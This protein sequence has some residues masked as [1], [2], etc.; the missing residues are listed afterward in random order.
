MLLTYVDA[1]VMAPAG[2]KSRVGR[3]ID[4]VCNQL[5][6]VAIN[7]CYCTCT[8]QLLRQLNLQD[9]V[10]VG[11][12][13]A[14]D[15]VPAG[16]SGVEQVVATG[17]VAEGGFA[18]L[19]QRLINEQDACSPDGG[20][21]AGAAGSD[22]GAFVVD[23]DVGIGGSSDIGNL[24][25]AI[26]RGDR[27]RIANIERHR[28][29]SLHATVL[30][31]RAG[32]NLPGGACKAGIF[33][34]AAAA[35][36]FVLANGRA[37]ITTPRYFA[38]AHIVVV[39]LQVGAANGDG[40]GGAGR[41][42]GGG[43][44]V[45]AQRERAT[46]AATDQHGDALGSQSAQA[47]VDGLHLAGREGTL[48][49]AIADAQ[50]LHFVINGDAVED[51]DKAL[52]K[53]SVGI[54]QVGLVVQNLRFRGET[55][56]QFEVHCRLPFA[57]TGGQWFG[58]DIDILNVGRGQANAGGIVGNVGGA[59]WLIEL[60][61]ANR[62]TLALEALL[63]ELIDLVGSSHLVA[64]Q[65][66]TGAVFGAVGARHARLSADA[67]WRLADRDGEVIQANDGLHQPVDAGGQLRVAAL[68]EKFAPQERM[69]RERNVQ[70]T[71]NIANRRLHVDGGMQRV[72]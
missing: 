29:Y 7:A 50:H 44:I 11:R 27:L 5:A 56:N 30:R 43:N 3:L 58:F 70:G 23:G 20:C 67:K 68:R 28:R 46:V 52:S 22:P 1:D 69:I 2:Y 25:Q 55:G 12:T 18:V 33:A 49:G 35:A 32:A 42:G 16:G 64:G 57:G 72:S 59:I 34:H 8:F 38:G 14:G 17:N 37:V 63:V 21:R 65:C 19:R 36:P 31:R 41:E 66:L 26:G 48:R 51:I 60:R 13:P 39:Y 47:V 45:Q 10:E 40:V 71:L 6:H 4:G 53:G 54:L 62:H 61:H 9:V 24:A 15:V